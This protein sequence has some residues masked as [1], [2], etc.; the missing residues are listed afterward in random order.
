M[1]TIG[2]RTGFATTR[3]ARSIAFF[4]RDG[5]E[6][7][8]IAA[9]LDDA[10]V[11]ADVTAPAQPRLAA[12]VRNGQDGFRMLAGPTDVAIADLDGAPHALVTSL[13][14]NGVQI[15]R[16]ARPTAPTPAGVAQDGRSG[17]D[18]LGGAHSV[19]IALIGG[20]TYAVV[21]AYVDGGL[22]LIDVTRPANPLAVAAVQLPGPQDVKVVVT[23]AAAGANAAA[24]GRG[25]RVYALVAQYDLN[26]IAVVDI[27]APSAPVAVAAV[28]HGARGA[29]TLE[30]A[31]ALATFAV[32]G[33]EYA[34]VAAEVS[35]GVQLLNVTDPRAPLPAGGARATS[36]RFAMLRGAASVAVASVENCTLA[37]VGSYLGDGAQLLDLS[38]PGRLVELAQLGRDARSGPPMRGVVDVGVRKLDGGLHMFCL[39]YTS[40]S[41]RD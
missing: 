36:E 22:Q 39:L 27:T 2:A 17:F 15:I 24:P 23:L 7:A 14:G 34:L 8:V 20:R 28:A 4:A 35:G 31:A 5:R 10:V 25:E 40:P 32:A 26:A 30:G 1:S 21:T 41:P 9:F 11:V 12:V 13:S 38:A 37:I 29:A 3:G 6:Y 16:L 18:M 19:A 33:I